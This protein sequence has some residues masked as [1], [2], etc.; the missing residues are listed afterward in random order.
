MT[1]VQDSPCAIFVELWV[2]LEQRPPHERTLADKPSA[3]L[4]DR[5]KRVLGEQ[6]GV[7]VAA[8]LR[9]ILADESDASA[10]AQL[11]IRLEIMRRIDEAFYDIHPRAL[12][13]PLLGGLPIARW[14]RAAKNLWNEL[15]FFWSDGQGRRLI[16]RGPLTRHERTPSA[17]SA[18]SVADRFAALSVVPDSLTHEGRKIEIYHRV[19]DGSMADGVR[20]GRLGDERVAFL[21]VAQDADDLEVEYKS[22]DG[23][24][25][26]DFR[27][28]TKVDVPERLLDGLRQV[29]D[30][31]I[32]MAPE[33]V[34]SEAC[35]NVV[36]GKMPTL[37]ATPR[38]LVVGSGHTE[39]CD[40]SAMRWNEARIVNAVGKELWRQRKLWPAS[41]S[42]QRSIELGVPLP[43]DQCC[44]EFNAAG[45]TLEVVDVVGLGRCVVLICQ[46]LQMGGLVEDLL[47]Q[48]QPDWIFVP[49]MDRDV[50]PGRWAHQR[51]FG[52][53][54][55]SRARF[56]MA[57][58]TAYARKIGSADPVIMGLAVGPLDPDDDDDG[59]LCASL[60]ATVGCS[61]EYAIIKW[62]G[63]G[64]EW[65]R[66]NICAD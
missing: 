45:K 49:I 10:I 2:D 66:T 37:G 57:T 5:I 19:I 4:S 3:D 24:H 47:Q 22:V 55:Q 32:A 17:S 43:H 31:D 60:K 44:F 29:T 46:D 61:V 35:A 58:N 12:T 23:G 16:A 63:G 36:C 64:S 56:L 9:A 42:A 39:V 53:S 18:D 28:G 40:T 38:M 27:V 20:L 7:A 51:A 54:R 26:V 1:A 21:A 62:R 25:Y 14:L 65:G 48:Y 33:L 34:I 8:G 50:S 59:R 15:G 11:R 41:M 52:Y 13:T 6:E 30:V